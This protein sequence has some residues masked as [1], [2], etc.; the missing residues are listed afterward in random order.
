MASAAKATVK[1]AGKAAAD[2]FFGGL[3]AARRLLPAD[4]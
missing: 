4:H 1:G 2:G 3:L